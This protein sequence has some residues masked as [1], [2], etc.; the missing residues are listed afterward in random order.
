MFWDPFS[1]LPDYKTLPGQMP[2]LGSWRTVAKRTKV[3][4][5]RDQGPLATPAAAPHHQGLPG[6]VQEEG[7][8]ESHQPSA[9]A[10][11]GGIAIIFVRIWGLI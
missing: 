4:L 6:D 2:L 9:A 10:F 7:A 1:L 11:S 8:G 3:H 5:A